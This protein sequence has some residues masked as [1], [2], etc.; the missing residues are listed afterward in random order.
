MAL[1]ACVV[2][3]ASSPAS[4]YARAFAEAE[5]A[6][7]AGRF[8]EAAAGFDRAAAAASSGRERDHAA[9][10]AAEM[11]MR[12]GDVADGAKRL[13]A[14]ARRDP[15]GEHAAHAAYELATMRAERDGDWTL[16]ASMP[17]R[18]PESALSR[19]ALYRVA[20][21]VDEQDGPGAGLAWLESI[22]PR[23]A[24]HELEAS[25]LYAIA[26]H[27]DALGDAARA[28]DEYLAIATRWPYPYGALWDDALFRA[29]EADERLGRYD[30]A[31]ADLERMLDER[32]TSTV[33][34]TYQRPRYGPALLRIAT[35]Y[36]DR[37][38]D[39]A[40]AR[41]ALHRLYAEF[42]TSESRDDALWM[43]AGLFVEDGDH[44]GACAR[45][46]TLVRDFPDSRYVPCATARCDGVARPAKSAAPKTCH[47]YLDARR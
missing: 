22:A 44:D 40:R 30:A 10:L 43:E 3:C 8:A 24:G 2:G 12:S 5:R 19:R 34:G 25:A 6:Q 36:R 42:T 32:E 45:L 17:V 35:L 27:H 37:L 41:A 20:A 39:R 14:I 46:A 26:R 15:E 23:L 33:M 16:L 47:A 11:A 21:H 7:T 29:S 28:R 9:Y 13:E 38:H 31:V 18:F 1:V 4:P